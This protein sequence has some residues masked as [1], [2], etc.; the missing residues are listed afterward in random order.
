[1]KTK[2]T[3]LILTATAGLFGAFAFAADKSA[4]DTTTPPSSPHHQ[5]PPAAAAEMKAFHEKALATYDVD[6]NGT[7]DVDERAVLHDDIRAGRFP[8]PSLVRHHMAHRMGHHAGLPPEILAQ[9]DTNKDGKLDETEHA[10]FAA[11]IAA[12]KVQPPHPRHGSPSSSE[13]KKAPSGS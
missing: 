12:G 13:G 6:K 10:A 1:M 5:V 2:S 7:L 3:L 8:A 4:A 11:D 9:Y